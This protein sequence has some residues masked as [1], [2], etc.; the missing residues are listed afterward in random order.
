MP[1][2]TFVIGPNYT[3]KTHFIKENF[4]GKD[5][6]IL[7][8]YDYQQRAYDEAGFGDR[9]PF[10][11]Q[12]DCLMKANLALLSDIQKFLGEGTDVV[13]EQ[14]FYKAKRRISYLDEIRKNVENVTAVVYVMAPS[15]EKWVQYSE[16]RGE[17]KK[18]ENLRDEYA[19][20]EFP[21]P[22]EGFDEIY[23]VTDE[24]PVL[25]MSEP[26]PEIVT[27]AR[28]ELAAE[29][30]RLALEEKEK[31]ERQELL[32]S[33][34]VRPFWHY[35]EVCGR[36]EFLTAEQAHDEGWDYPPKMGHFGLLSPRT[37][38]D[39]RMMDTLFWK[40]QQQKLPIVFEAELSPE[41]LV[42]WRRIKAEPESL[43]EE[44]ED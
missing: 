37:C 40:V 21:N 18:T 8:V 30:R 27:K 4:E 39:C 13:A 36:K 7:N 44:E 17:K 26:T 25:K 19:Q 16:M 24:G 20:L 34:N 3:G 12:F 31:R 42:T 23:E 32:E 1:R 2:V 11:A 29:A 41:E 5:C 43:L 14:T 6:K 22:A 35:C 38:G 9:I 10:H 15:L 28:E 33:M